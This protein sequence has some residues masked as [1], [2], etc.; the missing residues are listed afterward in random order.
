LT[1]EDN[2]HKNSELAKEG[3]SATVSSRTT[4]R[5]EET[6]HTFRRRNSINKGEKKIEVEVRAG[7]SECKRTS[8]TLKP[9]EKKKTKEKGTDSTGG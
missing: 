2:T 3:E 1:K 6:H 8:Q 5:T 9:G 7:T 4:P